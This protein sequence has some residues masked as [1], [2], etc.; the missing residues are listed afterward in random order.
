MVYIPVHV[1]AVILL[2]IVMVGP[3]THLVKNHKSLSITNESQL[4][5]KNKD[6][7]IPENIH[8]I[9]RAVSWNSEGEGG[10][11]WTGIPK[12]WGD[13]TVWNSKGMGGGVFQ[14]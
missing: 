10:V 9:P 7:V 12:T 14:L 3:G 8:T 11:S 1:S 5:K 4:K 6:W 13:N 2:Q